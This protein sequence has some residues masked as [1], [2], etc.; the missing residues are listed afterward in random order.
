MQAFLTLEVLPTSLRDAPSVDAQ[1]SMNLMQWRVLELGDG[2]R[3]LAGMLPE[4]PT[5]R[6]T[7]A[8]LVQAGRPD[9][10]GIGPHV[11]TDWIAVGGPGPS[12]LYRPTARPARV[13]REGRR[14][15]TI[16]ECHPNGRRWLCGMRAKLTVRASRRHS[17]NTR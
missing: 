6:V 5:L 15:R 4:R 2:A 13:Q 12:G 8:I 7:T 9:H 11:H 16:L 17:A 1:P 10:D 3:V 14:H